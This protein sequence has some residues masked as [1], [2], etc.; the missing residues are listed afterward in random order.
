MNAVGFIR[1]ENKSSLDGIVGGER[2]KF[3]F[4]DE[5]SPIARDGQK[6]VDVMR[7]RGR[8]GRGSGG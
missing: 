1:A 2:R 5:E 7:R 4:G 3:D 8:G 6:A